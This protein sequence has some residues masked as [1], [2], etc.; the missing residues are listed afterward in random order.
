MSEFYFIFNVGFNDQTSSEGSNFHLF[1][2]STFEN[3]YL[4]NL[5]YV[6]TNKF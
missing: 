5:F 2:L 1:L 6:C 3:H 4:T